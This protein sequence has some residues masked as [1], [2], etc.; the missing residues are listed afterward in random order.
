[1]LKP[2]AKRLILKAKEA[3]E[4]TA[5][6]LVLPSS[7]Q[8]K[9]QMGEVVALGPEIEEEDGVKVGDQVIYKSYSATEVKDQGQDFL[10]IELK[11]VLA[12]VEK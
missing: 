5:S 1:M 11:E 8:E 3:E 9:Q 4:I 2:L 12:V 6:G 7:A 10:I